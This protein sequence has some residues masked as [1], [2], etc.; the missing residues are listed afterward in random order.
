MCYVRNRDKPAPLAL[1]AILKAACI[2]T[3]NQILAPIVEQLGRRGGAFADQ[4][5]HS[6]LVY[7]AVLLS[8]ICFVLLAIF[9]GL[10]PSI[11]MVLL[12]LTNVGS[13]MRIAMSNTI[14]QTMS[15]DQIHFFLCLL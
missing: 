15:K 12:L 11:I 3:Y 9:V 7:P 10:S 2:R 13:F 8:F 14:S 6:Y 1:N 4:K 5:G